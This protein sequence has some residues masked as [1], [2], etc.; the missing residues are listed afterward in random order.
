MRLVVA[1]DPPVNEAAQATWACR[2]IKAVLHLGPD[3][4][5][6]RKA[7]GEHE[8]YPLRC[9]EY[10]LKNYRP[11]NDKAAEGDMWLLELSYDELFDYPPGRD[12][13]PR[14]RVAFAAELLDLADNPVDPQAAMQALPAAEFMNR[15]SVE[16][17]AVRPAIIL[18]G[19][20]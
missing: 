19:R 13:D 17:A 8:T 3:A 1:A 6:L 9:R 20:P 7:P 11:G 15:L 2:K 12:F 4:T 16:S 14:Q 18:R 5:Y 10:H